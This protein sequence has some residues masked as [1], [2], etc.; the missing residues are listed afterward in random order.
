MQLKSLGGIKVKTMKDFFQAKKIFSWLIFFAALFLPFWVI[1]IFPDLYHEY[2]LSVFQKWAKAWELGWQNIYINCATCNYPILGTFFSG[3]LFSLIDF[4]NIAKVI[5]RFRY[6]LAIIDAL[7]VLIM[8]MILARLK[9]KNAQFW[10]GLIGLLPSS[11][12]GS[13]VWGQ[14]DNIGQLFLL[15][16]VLLIIFFNSKE[17]NAAMYYLF[18]AASGILLSLMLLTKQLVY[19]SVLGLAIVLAVN[20]VLYSRTSGK[21]ITSMVMVAVFVILPILIVDANLQLVAPYRSHIQYILDTGS[22]HG[23]TISSLGLNVWALFTRD[24]L[25]NSHDPLT[26]ST[27]TLQGVTPYGAGMVLFGALNIVIL[28][29]FVRD[30]YSNFGRN[31]KVLNERQVLSAILYISMVN[32]VFNFALTGTHERYLFYFFPLILIASLG[33]RNH[34]SLTFSILGAVLY[35]IYLYGYLGGYIHRESQVIIQV[36]SLIYL[37]FFIFWIIAWVRRFDSQNKAAFIS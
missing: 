2:D 20:I 32:A 21:I 5:N 11:W 24:A 3:G 23:D 19:F 8:W 15:T 36:A 18:L 4:K 13:S 16:F 34:L 9:V 14:I 10:A 22:N 26:I 12:I 29:L 33:Y 37:A 6:Y 27:L 30:V 35:G 1:R 31:E 28:F 17:R 7:N 25:G